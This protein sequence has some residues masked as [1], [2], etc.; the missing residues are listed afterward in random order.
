MKFDPNNPKACAADVGLLYIEHI[1]DSIRPE[2]IAVLPRKLALKYRAV[3]LVR[4]LGPTGLRHLIV[5]IADPLDI[6]AV[7][8]LQYL[9]K[10]TVEPVIASKAEIKRALA[11]YYGERKHG[12]NF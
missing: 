2:V 6:E 11:K 9:L 8:S 1:D 4:G 7:D 5:A 3:P 10:I 12:S